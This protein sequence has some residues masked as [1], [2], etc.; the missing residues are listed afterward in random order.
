MP[1]NPTVDLTRSRSVWE[2]VQSTLR[3][4]SQY[5]WL[6][7]VLAAVVVGPWELLK[8][9]ITG[10]GPL[11]HFRESFLEKRSLEL[12]DLSIVTPL[13]SVM[14]IRAVT[15]IGEGRRPH[16]RS[17]VSKGLRML[18]V[19]GTAV[20]GAGIAIE[21]GFLVFVIPGILLS[22]RYA[23]V[24]QAAAVEERGVRQAWRSSWELTR[25]NGWH[26]FGLFVVAGLPLA[27]VT[28][29]AALLT[30]GAGTSAGSVALGIAL[31]AIVVSFAALAEALLY[32]DL[33]ARR[34][35]APKLRQAPLPNESGL[36][37]L[38]HGRRR[39]EAPS[40]LR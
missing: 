5:P 34:S 17:V 14:H 27:G 13:I 15:L 4:Y 39:S 9:V 38:K 26:V 28:I 16:L 37:R 11:G 32:F 2:I 29:G 18:P 21:I 10:Y 19:A 8:L 20:V 7:F 31:H 25:N 33:I 12:I 22:I 40:D 3:L 23:V 1:P 35:G 24:A 36:Q 6:F 30:T